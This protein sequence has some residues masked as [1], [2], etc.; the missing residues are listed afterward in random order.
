MALLRSVAARAL[1]VLSGEIAAGGASHA[2]Q[3]TVR[4]TRLVASV[5]TMGSSAR[6]SGAHGRFVSGEIIVKFK[7]GVS[8]KAKGDAHQQGRGSVKKEIARSG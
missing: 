7:P 8:G 3:N 6:T 5:F 2:G 4:S 1:T